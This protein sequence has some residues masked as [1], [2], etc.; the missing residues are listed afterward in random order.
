MKNFDTDHSLVPPGVDLLDIVNRYGAPI[1]ITFLDNIKSQILKLKDVFNRAIENNNYDASFYTVNANKANYEYL[2]I[3]QAIKYGDG[4]E[5]SSYYDL[6]ITK[7]IIEK[8]DLKN[9]K[10][11]ICNGYKNKDYI[12]EI[13]KSKN[14]GWHIIP[15][16]D[17]LEEYELY[18]KYNSEKNYL[19]PLEVGIRVHLSSQY[20]EEG[21]VIT[22]DRFGVTL[23]EFNFIIEDLKENTNLS[24]STI[25]FHQRGFDYEKD[26]YI[27]NIE[28]AF[29]D[30]YVKAKNTFDS[31]KNFDIGGGTPL[32][33]SNDFDYDGWA[34][35]TIK[36]IYDLCKKNNIKCPNIISENGKY[37]RKNSQ[38]NIYEVAKVK[39]TDKAYPWYIVDGC[40][41]IAMPEYYALGEPMKIVPLNLL[42]NKPIKARLCGM[43]CDCDDVFY[44]KDK[45]YIELP[46][47]NEDETLY[48]AIMGTGSY[49]DSMNGKGGVHHCLIPE[50]RDLVLWTDEFGDMQEYL[51]NEIQSIEEIVKLIHLK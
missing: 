37:N 12:K 4:A 30:F 38:I 40:L 15:I 39:Y 47:I 16:I 22:D 19:S 9:N 5:C 44:E 23:D 20:I 17:C 29:N 26:K 49:Q 14:D 45:G 34:N 42:D 41:L 28:K 3:A 8:L 6:I 11:L 51:Q 10:Y 36:L 27:I 48:I 50:E 13:V 18:K 24:L 2:G 21:S 35:L 1:K 43:T 32:P 31:V 33:E 7:M 25:H 46:E